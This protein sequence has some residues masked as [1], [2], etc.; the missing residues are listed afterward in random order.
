MTSLLRIVLLLSGAGLVA[1]P[2]AA[3]FET[4]N[5][6]FHDK[7]TFRL[8]GRHIAVACESCHLKGVYKGTPAKCADC[9]W[10]RRQDDRFRLQLGSQCE[11]C[12]RPVAWT[13]AR[14]DHGVATRMP[15]NGAHRQLSCQSCHRN[16]NLRA[17]QTNCVS[18]HQNDYQSAR[19]PNH[20]AAGFPTTCDTCHR[21][22]DTTFNQARFD[23][24]ASFPLV[25][26]HAQQ[27][28]ATCHK[29][30]VFRGTARDCVGCHRDAYNRTTAPNHVAA[31]FST[32]CESCH[33]ATDSSFR[34]ANFNHAAVFPLVGQHAQQVCAACHQNNVFRGTPRDCIGCHRDAYNR[35]TAPNHVAA[36]FS[37]TCESC[38]R[39]TDSSFRGAG[40]N[41]AAVFALVGRHAQQACAACHQNGVFRGTPRDCVG[42]HRDVYSRTT[43]PS[44][45]AAGFPTTCESCHRATDSTWNQGTFNHRFPIT[46]GPHRASCA[47]CHQA[48][49]SFQNFT[50]LTCHEHA[51]AS[52]DSKHRNRNGYRYESRACYSC[53]PTG[54]H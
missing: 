39:A 36:G 52:M 23:H 3:Q 30:N 26:Q 46:S 45:A 54:R 18:C 9:H 51:Q 28:C 25:G 43:A 38:H 6:Q 29:N 34:G 44:H 27:A 1:A 7:T 24:R 41:H 11:Q 16:D 2:A 15:L 49:T 31:G 13:G 8:E 17:A 12:H 48:G 33:R 53:H 37:T 47:T 21:A 5:R 42:C 35:T 20:V 50:C 14:F 10:E 32:T 22:S 40:F 4:P 19:A